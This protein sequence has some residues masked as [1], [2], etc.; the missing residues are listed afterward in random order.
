MRSTALYAHD[1]LHAPDGM[2]HGSRQTDRFDDGLVHNH[3]WAVTS[4]EAYPRRSQASTMHSTHR[5]SFATIEASPVQSRGEPAR[6]D[7]Q[8]DDGLVHNHHWAVT[9]R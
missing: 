5:R 6:A 2:N 9:A 8:H 7:H 1:A 3:Q 4:H